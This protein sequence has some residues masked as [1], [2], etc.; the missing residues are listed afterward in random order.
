VSQ[1]EEFPELTPEALAAYHAAVNAV[2]KLGPISISSADLRRVLAASLR[3][4]MEQTRLAGHCCPNY[5]VAI[6][7]NLHSPPPPPP[8]LAQA[9]A[10]DL[11]TQEG[12]ET[13][14]AFLATLRE[15]GQP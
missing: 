14:S 13:V 11:E 6:A 12:V 2:S 10:A 7:N 15:A 3:E 1:H 8:T 4:A 5:F 9:L